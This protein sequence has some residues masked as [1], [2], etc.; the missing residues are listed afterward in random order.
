MLAKT[1]ADVSQS[2]AVILLNYV[3]IFELTQQ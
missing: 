1:A 3:T 2:A